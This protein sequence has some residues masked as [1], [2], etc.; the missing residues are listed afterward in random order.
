MGVHYFAKWGS[1]KL[2][3]YDGEYQK[4]KEE[5]IKH[6][7]AP[8]GMGFADE[9]Q[10]TEAWRYIDAKI[11]GKFFEVYQ[12]SRKCLPGAPKIGKRD[13][14]GEFEKRSARRAINDIRSLVYG[15]FKLYD[16]LV[17]LTFGPKCEFD[18][19]NPKETN[20]RVERFLKKVRE[21]YPDFKYVKVLQIQRGKRI[22]DGRAPTKNIHYH[23]ICNLPYQT[24]DFRKFHSLWVYGGLGKNGWY[25]GSDV[26]A[27]VPDKHNGL[28]GAFNYVTKYITEDYQDPM[29]KGCK[30]F[31]ASDNLKKPEPVV[32]EKRQAVM[33]YIRLHKIKPIYSYSV[34]STYQGEIQY[35]AYLLDSAP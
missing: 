1:E 11:T 5:L 25:R 33:E 34:W 20:P 14:T 16:K 10:V 29:L 19:H 2:Y 23:L 13:R 6:M 22:D 4:V 32:G 8:S 9:V 21:L 12:T 31:S 15:N 35:K 18:T 3:S 27:I 30:H 7:P 26:V 24:D 17:T 28:K